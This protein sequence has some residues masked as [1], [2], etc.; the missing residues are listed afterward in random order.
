MEHCF[1]TCSSRP[2]FWPIGQNDPAFPIRNASRF[3][4]VPFLPRPNHA[5][6]PLSRYERK[7]IAHESVVIKPTSPGQN[8]SEG[9]TESSAPPSTTDHPIHVIFFSFLSAKLSRPPSMAEEEPV[10]AEAQALEEV[11]LA[12]FPFF[13]SLFPCPRIQFASTP[14]S[15][16]NTPIIQPPIPKKPTYSNLGATSSASSRPS[17]TASARSS[18]TKHSSWASTRRRNSSAR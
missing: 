12:L 11:C 5:D 15:N 9:S 4:R 1:H 8:G 13:L 14:P 16:L 2:V 6:F 18:T 10:D 7:H 17:G 3:K